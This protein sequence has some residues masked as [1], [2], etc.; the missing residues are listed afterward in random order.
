MSDPA[1]PTLFIYVIHTE[2]LTLRALRIHGLIQA[3]RTL[4]MQCG[5]NVKPILILKPN[6]TELQPKLSELNEKVSYEPVGDELFDSL[7][8]VLSLEMI[9]NIEKHKEAW[10][11]IYEAPSENP[12]DLFLVMEDD[13][14]MVPDGLQGFHRILTHEKTNTRMWD[15]LLLGVSDGSFTNTTDIYR[16]LRDLIKIMPCKESYFVSQQTA[17]VMLD[18]WSKYRFPLRVQMSWFMH[19]NGNLR[20]MHPRCRCFLDGSKVGTTP[21]AIHPNNLL[22]FNREYMDLY[23][24]LKKP[25]DEIA[26]E[27]PQILQAYKAIE[28]LQNPD[29]IHILGVLLFKA[30]KLKEAEKTLQQGIEEMKKQQGILNSRSDVLNN[31]VQLYEHLQEDLTDI[32]A[33]PSKFNNPAIAVSDI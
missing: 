26:R 12:K 32:F 27:L 8:Q 18:A 22:V 21:S 1:T 6:P 9:S 7:R 14:M 30:G 24:Y 5:Y 17:K 13:A 19:T 3:L 33:S 15:F 11:R 4:A 2:N 16:N 25:N 20:I 28:H 10:K 29:I 31:M 23:T